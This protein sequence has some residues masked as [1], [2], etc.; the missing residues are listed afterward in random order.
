MSKNLKIFLAV[1]A[2]ISVGL[3]VSI[4]FNWDPFQKKEKTTSNINQSE[5][6]IPTPVNQ[7]P[8]DR[9]WL[10]E[11]KEMTVE[12][13]DNL[14]LPVDEKYLET[15]LE[16]PGNAQVLSFFLD[17]GTLIKAIFKGEVTAIAK[18]QKPF[19]NDNAFNEIRITRE[20][21][22]L[23]ASYVIY[24][25]VLVAEGD[26]I[27]QGKEIAKAKEGGLGFRSGTNLSL[28]IHDKNDNFIKITKDLFIKGE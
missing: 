16:S 8:T 21:G 23:W 4:I 13:K 14:F 7:L 9:D 17:E 15:A 11:L 28:W 5:Q 19:P 1:L 6:V 20:D 24:G 27:E 2:L 3:S 22:D 18:D 12:N 25:D 26:I 10:P